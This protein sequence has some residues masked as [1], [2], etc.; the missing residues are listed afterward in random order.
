MRT[1]SVL[2]TTSMF[3]FLLTATIFPYSFTNEAVAQPIQI[4]PQKD[5]ATL[6]I[7]VNGAGP[8][9]G[10]ML[11]GVF[12]YTA[13]NLTQP[14][15]SEPTLVDI[16]NMA[17]KDKS[18]ELEVGAFNFTVGQVEG[19]H[20]TACFFV[21]DSNFTQSRC[22]NVQLNTKSDSYNVT[23]DIGGFKE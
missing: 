20:M 12:G 18:D 5:E 15:T 14:I 22:N 11:M 10:H 21:P 9:T 19:G 3:T 8:D 6:H 2:I 1:Y 4:K 17:Q 13:D 7:N 16:G 23:V